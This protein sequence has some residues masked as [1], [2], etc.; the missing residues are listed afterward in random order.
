MSWNRYRKNVVPEKVSESVSEKFGT[1]KKSWNGMRKIWNWNWF[2]L[3]I[4]SNFGIGKSLGTGIGTI[5]YRKKY[6]YRYRKLAKMLLMDWCCWCT[7][8]LL[9]TEWGSGFARR[10]FYNNNLLYFSLNLFVTHLL[11]LASFLY[12]Q[13]LSWNLWQPSKFLRPV[14]DGNFQQQAASM[15]T[16][17]G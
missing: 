13:L 6:W 17:I 3:P 4:F 9:A 11:S 1:G 8:A 2:S 14:P 7:D 10:L 15:E 5:W 12:S 16:Q